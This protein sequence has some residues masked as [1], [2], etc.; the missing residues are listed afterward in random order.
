MRVL[1]PQT[2]VGCPMVG[3]GQQGHSSSWGWGAPQPVRLS[4]PHESP[5][6]RAHLRGCC[7]HDT[8]LTHLLSLALIRDSFPIVLGAQSPGGR[9]GPGGGGAS[10]AWGGPG[11]RTGISCA[12]TEF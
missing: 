6:F 7:Q 11:C 9:A 12:F 4:L 8:S 5:S 1:V 3:G 2:A 10:S